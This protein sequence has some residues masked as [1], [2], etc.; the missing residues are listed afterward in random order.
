MAEVLAHR[1]V[2]PLLSDDY[3]SVDGMLV[4]S[5]VSMERFQPK[6]GDAPPDHNPGSPP[7]PTS[8][9][10]SNPKRPN[11]SQTVVRDTGE[12]AGLGE[13]ASVGQLTRTSPTWMQGEGPR[14]RA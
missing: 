7:D 1:E 3:F 14:Q 11:P 12:G 8:S 9:P 6:A 10:M 5:W 2:A 4:K 13:P